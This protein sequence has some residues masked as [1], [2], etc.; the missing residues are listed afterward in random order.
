M[1][2]IVKQNYLPL[3]RIIN[4]LQT[5]ILLIL[6]ETVEFR[7][8]PVKAKFGEQKRSV[9]LDEGSITFTAIPNSP[10]TGLKPTCLGVR[11]FE[12]LLSVPGHL[13]RHSQQDDPLVKAYEQLSDF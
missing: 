3:V 10:T 1:S 11:F 7:M 13:Q 8:M 5:D 12:G 4:V 2:V 9:C 6:E